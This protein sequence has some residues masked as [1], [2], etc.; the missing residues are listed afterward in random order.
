[1]KL[2][3]KLYR[4]YVNDQELVVFGHVFKSLAPDKYEID[5]RGYR[6]AKSVYKMFTID[7]VKN[8]KVKLN[9]KDL[10]VVTKT[11]DDGYFR[12]NIPYNRFLESGCHAYSVS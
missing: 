3:I 11:V 5:R 8:V 12:F 2:D 10:E 1:M 7:P 6:H 9:F 4:G